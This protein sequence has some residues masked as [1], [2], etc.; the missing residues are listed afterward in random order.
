M[1]A[2]TTNEPPSGWHQGEAA[3]SHRRGAKSGVGIDLTITLGSIIQASLVATGLIMYIAGYVGKTDEVG[4]QL[5]EIKV[6][7]AAQG[8]SQAAD[9]QKR[10]DDVQRQISAQQ[11]ESGKHFDEVQH[12][13]AGLPDQTAPLN[14]AESRLTR[15]ESL[16]G[17]LDTHLQGVERMTIEDRA[18]ITALGRSSEAPL[19]RPR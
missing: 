8:A 18:D 15:M 13:I 11:T 4:K 1:T 6:T 5:G 3:E 10:F 14:Q 9:M 2:A 17:A 7:A 12:Q 16:V 19:R